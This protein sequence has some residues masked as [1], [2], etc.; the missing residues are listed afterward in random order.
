[1]HELFASPVSMRR[2]DTFLDC[3]GKLSPGFVKRMDFVIYA[4]KDFGC[5]DIELLRDCKSLESI[6]NDFASH[7]TQRGTQRQYTTA[8]AALKA[9]RKHRYAVRYTGWGSGLKGSDDFWI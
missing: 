2:L 6:T 7:V 4:G 9:G 3:I 8:E 5:L 1:M